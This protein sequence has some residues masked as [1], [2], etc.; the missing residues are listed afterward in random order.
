MR[1]ADGSVL[2]EYDDF[3]GASLKYRYIYA[4]AQ[5]IA[6]V[7]VSGKTNIADITYLISFIFAGGLPP[8][9]P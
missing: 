5:R 9:C 7:D 4:G 8:V 3:A 6:M 2:A 1:G